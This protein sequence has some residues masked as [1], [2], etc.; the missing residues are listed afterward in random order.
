M[1]AVAG[2]RR[3]VLLVDDEGAILAALRRNLH[4]HFDVHLC[5]NA[6]DALAALGRVPFSA[7]ISDMQMPGMS[8][9]ELL[10]RARMVAPDTTRMLLTGHSDLAMAIQAIDDGQLF[11]FL[12]K[13][14]GL[15]TL[16]RH[17]DAAI[18]RY[19]RIGGDDP[20]LRAVARD[21]HRIDGSGAAAVHYQPI[22]SL[23]DGRTAGVEAT[24]TV[25]AGDTDGALRRWMLCA[26]C[27]EVASWPLEQLTLT[28][29]LSGNVDTATLRGDIDTA[30]AFSALPASRL[31]I[32]FAQNTFDDAGRIADLAAMLHAHG[33][34]IGLDNVTLHTYNAL[35]RTHLDTVKFAPSV[36]AALTNNGDVPA[37]WRAFIQDRR[38]G[39]TVFAAD[40]V[41]RDGQREACTREGFAAAQ[42][43]LWAP[44]LVPHRLLEALAS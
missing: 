40:G 14:C 38:E 33:V 4:A 11:R 20:L 37:A 42:G 7:L 1:V 9:A 32:S 15:D 27:D 44:A 12:N 8:G 25:T 30:L 5:D 43:S 16:R 21:R 22:V 13:P 35:P 17:L 19:D 24:M 2:G 18:A 3:P 26:A 29:K 36:V 6:D 28:V 31:T 10:A 39:G 41:E 23:A 34:S